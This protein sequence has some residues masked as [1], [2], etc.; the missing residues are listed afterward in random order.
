MTFRVRK[1]VY[2]IA[3]KRISVHDYIATFMFVKYK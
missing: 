1:G 3:E 2:N